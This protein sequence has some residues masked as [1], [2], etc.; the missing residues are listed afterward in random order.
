MNRTHYEVLGLKATCTPEE[1]RSAYRRLVL[2]HHPDRSKAPE[3]RAI[4]MAAT[5]AHEVLSSP[6]RRR[7][8]DATIQAEVIKRAEAAKRAAA[9]GSPKPPNKVSPPK[10]SETKARAQVTSLA[11]EVTRLTLLHSRSQSAEA[12]RLAR[13][14]LQQDSRQPI[15]YAVLGDIARGRGNLDEAA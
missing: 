5:E 11:S 14:I 4:F 10:Q 13:R 1:I 9:G 15:P 3:S 12:E 6:D 2:Q 8:Y 7:H